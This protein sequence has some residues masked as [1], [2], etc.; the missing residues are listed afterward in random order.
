MVNGEVFFVYEINYKQNLVEN[1]FINI[2]KKYRI[3]FSVI[4]NLS[5][6]L[7]CATTLVIN[8]NTKVIN[9]IT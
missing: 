7:R 6:V 5:T 3:K 1:N 8:S 9:C 2:N 4:Q